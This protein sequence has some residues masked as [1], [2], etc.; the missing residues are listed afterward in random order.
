MKIS[1]NCAS[2]GVAQFAEM[3]ESDMNVDPDL[4]ELVKKGR[5]H[6]AKP[7]RLE[8]GCLAVNPIQEAALPYFGRDQKH[9]RPARTPRHYWLAG[10]SDGDRWHFRVF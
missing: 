2:A 1:R 6:I 5:D 4:G 8:T 9:P 7:A 10:S 3:G